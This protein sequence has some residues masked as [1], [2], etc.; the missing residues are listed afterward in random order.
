[1]VFHERGLPPPELQV[2]I[3]GEGGGKIARVDFFWRE[4]GVVAEADGLLKYQAGAD[5]IAELK[6]DRLLREQGLDVIHFTWEELF[7]EPERVV[8]ASWRPSSALGG[9][10]SLPLTLPACV[11]VKAPR[12]PGSE[13]I[14]GLGLHRWRERW[15]FRHCCHEGA[16]ARLVAC[17]AC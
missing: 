14:R 7:R 9:Y 1:M 8:G 13:R 17:G 5:A 4:Y 10:A 12:R 2:A 15:V 6:R 3:L 11:D 16:A